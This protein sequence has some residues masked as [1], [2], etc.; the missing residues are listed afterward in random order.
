MLTQPLVVAKHHRIAF[1]NVWPN[2]HNTFVDSN[3]RDLA[4]RIAH[5][6]LPTNDLLYRHD[7]TRNDYC[8]LCGAERETLVHLCIK[9]PAVSSLWA[10]ILALTSDITDSR[11]S[12]WKTTV[13]LNIMRDEYPKNVK[14]S[15]PI[16]LV[17]IYN[18]NV[19]VVLCVTS[20]HN[21]LLLY[22]VR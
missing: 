3:V 16:L 5:E 17:Y 10:F 14:K 19:L 7:V 21:V 9:C 18:Y 15:V 6:C 2:I 13:L 12:I 1:H 8:A 22:N 4:W 11:V 20:V